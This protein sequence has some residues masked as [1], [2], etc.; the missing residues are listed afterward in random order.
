MTCIP[1]DTL[2]VQIRTA[3]IKA[4]EGYCLTDR[5]RDRHDQNYIPHPLVGG[6]LI[7]NFVKLT[8]KIV[9]ISNSPHHN[10]TT[11]NTSQALIV[12]RDKLQ[13]SKQSTV[14]TV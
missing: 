1:G 5:Q 7:T 6:Q 11:D 8:T 9:S 10:L 13:M 4:F 2:D 14:M 12:T 3:C